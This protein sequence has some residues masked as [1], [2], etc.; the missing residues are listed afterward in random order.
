MSKTAAALFLLLAALAT[1]QP[2]ASQTRPRR[3]SETEV[4]Y[5]DSQP[6]EV[7]ARPRTT[8]AGPL[9]EGE[10]RGGRSRAGT[11]LRAGMKAAVIAV[12]TRGSVCTPSRGHILGGTPRRVPGIGG[13][14]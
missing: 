9:R 6:R 12:T 7:A 14:R 8:G 5:S 4:G 2:L 1:A 13:R 11:I 3:V 10:R